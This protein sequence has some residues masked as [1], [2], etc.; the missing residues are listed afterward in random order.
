MKKETDEFKGSILDFQLEIKAEDVTP[1]GTFKGY[2]SVF[3]NVDSGGDVVVAGAFKD[4][5]NRGGRNGNGIAMLWQHSSRYP[6]GI[7]T[8]L[9]EDEK[10]LYV[11][12]QVEPTATPDGIPVLN[13]MR[14]G[15]VKGL[16]IGFN[17]L[18]SEDDEKRKVR[19]LKE[20]EL[21]EISLVT[22][23][24]NKRS[25]ITNVKD[26][27]RGAKTIREF[28]DALRE[29]GVSKEDAKWIAGMWRKEHDD[30]SNLREVG[31]TDGI[32][33]LA[34]ALREIRS[35][36]DYSAIKEAMKHF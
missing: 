24:M 33:A 17:T 8:K 5:I 15:G 35:E 27:I 21:W 1:E 36:L 28:E 23:P 2:G 18:V 22:F 4:T 12:G 7:W 32:N 14:L 3:G 26:T 31:E 34:M 11:E 6:I 25:I 29:V 16:S 19:Y 13:M 10:G 9:L 30:Q 20:I